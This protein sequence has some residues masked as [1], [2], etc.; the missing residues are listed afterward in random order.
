MRPA[1]T[2]TDLLTD[3][4]ELYVGFILRRSLS[5]ASVLTLEVKVMLPRETSSL[6]SLLVSIMVLLLVADDC[7]V[8]TSDSKTS[9]EA[10]GDLH[11]EGGS[12]GG[13]GGENFGTS[14]E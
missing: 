7:E 4:S 3:K 8:I 11:G 5:M 1:S 14:V 6:C 2:V 10:A 13:G 12:T 9:G